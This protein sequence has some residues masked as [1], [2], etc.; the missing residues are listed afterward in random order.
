MKVAPA[1]RHPTR[2]QPPGRVVGL[3]FEVAEG[4]EM[5]A[6]VRVETGVGKRLVGKSGETTCW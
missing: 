6:E 1:S 3:G 4:V 2:D 5:V